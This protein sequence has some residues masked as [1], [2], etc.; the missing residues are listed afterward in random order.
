MF[1][2]SLELNGFKSFAQKTILEF[3]KGITAIVGP[4]G[5]G[6]SNIIDA[7]RWILGEREAK[8]LRSV[9]SE[10]LIFAGTPK[11]ARV[12][13]AQVAINFDNS[14]GFFPVNFDEVAIAREVSRDGNSTYLLNKS[15]VRAKDIVDF[16]A[17]A[18]LG[19]KGISIINQGSSDLFVRV[20][21][22]ERRMMIEEVL[23][24][25]EYQLKKSEAERKLKNTSLNLEKIKMITEEVAP[26]LRTLKRQ[27]SK[28]RARGEKQ[29]ELNEIENNYFGLKLS[30]IHADLAKTKTQINGFDEKTSNKSGELKTLEEKLKEVESTE[31]QN[32]KAEE[33]KT[34]KFGF[35]GKQSQIQ[36]ELGRI[37]AQLEFLSHRLDD[38][39]DSFK[40]EDLIYLLRDI[41]SSLEKTLEHKE[42]AKFAD[43][44]KSLALK[45]EEFFKKPSVQR[46]KEFK[47][48]E[49][50]KNNIMKE[51]S[52]IEEELKAIE[53]EENEI[54]K[55]LEEFN[56]RFKHAFKLKEAKKE[57]IREFENQRKYLV[58]ESEKLNIKLVDIKNEWIKNERTHEEFNNLF[59]NSRSLILNP[60]I[61][62]LEKKMFRLRAELMGIGEIDEALVKEAQEV[63]GY[64]NHLSAQSADLEKASADLDNLIVELK[65]EISSRFNKAFKDISDQFNNFFKLM[66]GGGSA[67]LK[68]KTTNNRQLTTNNEEI[69]LEEQKQNENEEE[70]QE[71]VGVEIELNLPKKKIHSLDILSGGEKSLVS[72]AALFALV[73]VSPPPFLV[74]DEIDA[75]LDEKNSARFADLV[76]DFA[77]K[78]QFVVVTHNRTVMEAADVL[79]GVTMN[80]DGTSK[81]LSLKLEEVRQ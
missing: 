6:K 4:N 59:L 76:K 15:E 12:G 32:K 11:K 72:I 74:L 81:L 69:T 20:T 28:Y 33:L 58:F 8:N 39:D 18:R 21:P 66:F 24:L 22:E 48:L 25:K 61:N 9:K 53:K 46:S 10:D 47:I 31:Y 79:Y 14:S 36:K 50:A 71:K 41:K 17:R 5:S 40:K 56:E 64:Y 55:N 45:I 65:E 23:G 73:S 44:V 30:G 37:E 19:T 27:V 63:E 80:D 34:K 52:T 16:F 38:A 7:V 51:I 62:D 29:K 49:E 1:L 2:K 13:M 60:D 67:K 75:P 78:V 70:K 77:K 54:A 35:A 43:S 3:P 68:I 42:L 57:E 26:R